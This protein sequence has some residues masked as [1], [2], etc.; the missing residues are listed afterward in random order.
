M[1]AAVRRWLPPIC[2]LLIVAAAWVFPDGPECPDNS[3]DGGP[4]IARVEGECVYALQFKTYLRDISL[5]LGLS[6]QGS[7]ADQ[8]ILG[9]Y[10]RG[11]QLLASE[12][13]LENAAF[14]NL[15]QDFTLYQLAVSEGHSPLDGEIMVRMGV[16]RER[17]GGL[18]ALLELHE[19]ARESDLAGFRNL[20]ERPYV[21]QFISVQGEEHLLALFE[22]AGE[23]DLSG[24]ADGM[25]IHAALLESVG[26][27]RYWSEV[28]ADQARR[29]VS[30]ESL[31]LAIDNKEPD[32]SSDIHWQDLREKTWGGTVIELTDAAPK[33]ITLANVRSYMTGQHA[34]E[35][36]LLPE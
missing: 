31:R 17:I 23:T 1:P 21:R 15:A 5:S 32:L 35:R 27:D 3:W 26:E 13:G 25:E 30:I 19:V 9:D 8:S 24:A 12:F 22:Q 33:S 10:F 6:G 18:R 34:L 2:L 29:L 36:A 7:E 4:A 11:R 16:A 14:A 20:I 28:F